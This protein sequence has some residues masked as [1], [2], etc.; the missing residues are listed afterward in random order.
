MEPRFLVREN[1][2]SRNRKVIEGLSNR[3][4]TVSIHFDYRYNH[5][6][7]TC[8]S[9]NWTALLT[10]TQLLGHSLSSLVLNNFLR[11]SQMKILPTRPKH[12]Q[13]IPR[14][15]EP[16]VKPGMQLFLCLTTALF[17]GGWSPGLSR[18]FFFEQV[19]PRLMNVWRNLRYHHLDL[20]S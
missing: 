2:W 10:L 18:G 7:C 1:G 14:N 11:P 4:S 16:F 8:T 13:Y 17:N 15:P 3:D 9:L 19:I 6:P 12:I 5:V 20:W